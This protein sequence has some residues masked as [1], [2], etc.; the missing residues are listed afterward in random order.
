MR[1]LSKYVKIE[2]L[3]T[4]TTTG[5][6]VDLKQ[7]DNFTNVAEKEVP[8]NQ[9]IAFGGG[10]IV[11]GVDDRRTFTA[12]LNTSSPSDINAAIRL[13]VAD[14]NKQEFD[15][16]DEYNSTEY[17]AGVNIG[18]GGG[19]GNRAQKQAKPENHFLLIQAATLSGTATVSY[20]D[21]SLTI[22]LTVMTVTN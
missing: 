2:T 3:D 18:E 14:P 20:S 19:T 13:T 8:N 21:S 1:L 4:L 12:D 17:E 16:V 10:R 11:G 22:P 6:S 7:V 5:S 9:V 15:F